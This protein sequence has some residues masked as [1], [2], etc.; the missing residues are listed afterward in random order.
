MR[1]RRREREK[2]KERCVFLRVRVQ[3]VCAGVGGLMTIAKDK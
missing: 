1:G 3:S 2:E